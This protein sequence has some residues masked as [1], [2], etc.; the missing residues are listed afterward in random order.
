MSR[1]RNRLASGAR[2][3]MSI[4]VV[5]RVIGFVSTLILA[6][7]L[8]PADFGV[9]AMGTAIQEILAAITS[10]GFTQALIR[11]PRRD[12]GAY[13]TAF[14]LNALT[15]LWIALVLLIAIPFAQTWYDDTRVTGVLVVLALVS[16]ITGLRNSGLVRY[17]CALDFR[18]FFAIAV[19][20]KSTSLVV[21]A[22]TAL[23]WRDYRALLA[24]MLVGAI[25]ETAIGY[26]LTR[27]RPRFTLEKARELFG[28]SAW[29]L[30]SQAVGMLGRRGQDLLI[31]QRMGAAILGQYAIALDVSTM[32]TTE[33]VAP[34]MRAVYP[35]YV[36]M[37]DDSGRF[38][39]AFSR[40]WGVIALLALPAA[41]GTACLA[42]MIVDVILGPK[43]LP[44]IPLMSLL[45]VIGALQA[46]GSCYWPVILTR[47]GPSANFK[48]TAV[49][50]ALSISSFAIAL[51][52]AGLETAISAWIA[53]GAIML[54]V[55]AR[56]VVRDLHGSYAPLLRA[57][58]RPGVATAL[59]SASILMLMPV[60]PVIE[61][62][63]GKA[64]LLVGLV[65]FGVL[66][67]SAAVGCLWLDGR[68][69]CGCGTGTSLCH[70]RALRFEACLKMACRPTADDLRRL[71]R[72]AHESQRAART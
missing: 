29:W 43:W 25:V 1:L 69:T 28:F 22:A 26:R 56:V 50:V 6:R 11:M 61:Q 2:W 52:I 41:A 46:M 40:V 59:M 48:L 8:A 66:V 71:N 9:V 63:G 65:A 47:L 37:K 10:F 51:W 38:F 62:W 19:V 5:E 16:L 55:G 32:A 23:L 3:T 70:R 35:G 17:E 60:L 72:S 30:M 31:G 57:L 34:V 33:I 12:H 24:A 58:I 39:S 27:F 68:S 54:V 53:S 49:G 67:Y 4:R 45:A 44:V 14:T 64:V 20:R 36:L 13:S 21:G 42:G 18:P 15:G 7:L